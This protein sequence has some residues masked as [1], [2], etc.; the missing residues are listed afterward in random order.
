M[1][2]KARSKNSCDGVSSHNRLLSDDC[3]DEFSDYEA[4]LDKQ[5]LLNAVSMDE[6]GSNKRPAG[7]SIGG[8]ENQNHNLNDENS[9]GT[10]SH[11]LNKYANNF[12]AN[13]INVVDSRL[14]KR[15]KLIEPEGDDVA[16]DS[17]D[18]NPVLSAKPFLLKRPPTRKEMEEKTQ[19]QIDVIVLN[20]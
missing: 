12:E 19:R 20:F 13:N 11:H 4:Q 3:N 14:S 17:T 7:Y 5:V 1:Y 15:S 8:H 16:V 18:N 10:D 6:R 9:L 2:Y